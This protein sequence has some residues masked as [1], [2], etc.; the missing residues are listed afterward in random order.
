MP[1]RF[2]TDGIRG[3]ANTE[4]TPE[5]ALALGRAAAR[6]LGPG[7]FV[8]GRD[9]RLSGAMLQAALSAGLSSEG[10][11]VVDVGVLPTPGVAWLAARRGTQ[12]AVISASHNSF[13]DNGIKL[14]GP[15]ATK[16]SLETEEA[17]QDE[18]DAI[19]GAGALGEGD[20]GK[21]PHGGAAVG[22]VSFDPG[23]QEEYIENLLAVVAG[24][25]MPKG[26]VVVDCAHGAA[27][28]VAPAVFERAGISHHVVFA[29]PE[30]TN[31][32]AGC[33]STH[34]GPLA[35]EV[36][37]RGARLGIA[38]DGDADRM[39]GVDH[40]GNVVDGDHLIA[41]FAADLKRSGGLVGDTVVVTVMSNLGLRRALEDAGTGVV[42]TPLGD[43]H[44]AEALETGG[45]VLGGEQSGHLIFTQHASTGDGILTALKLLELLGRTG[46]PLAELADEAMRRLPQVLLNVTVGDPAGLAGAAAVWSE[47]EAVRRELGATGRVLVRASGTESCVRIMV[48]APTV[49][50]AESCAKRLAAA[51]TA[52]LG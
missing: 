25:V 11:H 26:E 12:A 16:L 2:G 32:N 37:R 18:L 14:F 7:G 31:I 48:E 36:V 50:Q 8:V 9:T 13:E 5:F 45:Y 43:R 28:F 40:L 4:L 38:F 1:P 17:I 24:A 3:V 27:S 47:S 10:R 21:G 22:T 34:L 15:G 51:V 19:M 52:A 44:V 35:E 29:E 30:G 20:A 41:M 49:E 33:G 39:L 46:R 42:E 6:H 23:A